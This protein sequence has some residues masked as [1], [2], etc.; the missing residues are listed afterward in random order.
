VDAT[1]HRLTPHLAEAE[2]Q[3][4]KSLF[5]QSLRK[6]VREPFFQFLLL[7]AVIWAGVEYIEAQSERYVISV[8][9]AERQRLAIAY[10]QQYNQAPSLEQLQALTDRYV[11]Q[12]IFVREGK[13]LGL[14]KGDEIVE[15]RIAQKYEF[16]QQDLGAPD[17]PDE[18]T[19]KRWYD[20]HKVQY[21]TGPRVAF[22]QIYFS[23]D[24]D[25]EA[26]AKARAEKA[27][28]AL[29]VGKQTRA[30]G[31]GDAFPGPSDFPALTKDDAVRLFG[32]SQLSTALSDV[33][34][35]KWAGPFRSGY[36]WHL[37]FVTQRV[38]PTL[39]AFDSIKG[40]VADDYREDQR[41]LENARGYEKLRSKYRVAYEG[42]R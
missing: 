29:A 41:R 10:Q 16:L 11:R 3:P 32:E 20:T 38:A 31:L 28:T 42:G 21:I 27:L 35:G 36:G 19:L 25:G 23:I 5:A 30:P 22:S 12:Q 9:P 7:G 17:V 13:A 6:G 8:G 34:P 14:D 40:R 1:V 37:V 4:R 15:R 24:H 39:P 26:G 2:V 18:A 33:V